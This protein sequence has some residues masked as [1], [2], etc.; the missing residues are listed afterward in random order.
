[1]KKIIESFLDYQ[2]K[3]NKSELTI[4]SYVQEIELFIDE[5]DVK[6]ADELR[7][8]SDLDFLMNEWLEKM[9]KKYAPQTVNKKQ[10]CLSAFSNYL[11]LKNIIPTNEIKKINKVKN[12]IKKIDIYTDEEINT[13]FNY[14]ENKIKEDKFKRKVDREVFKMQ[15]CII[16]LL[17]TSGMRISEVVKMRL[18]DIDIE[19]TN[20][21]NIRGKGYND[22]V[23]RKNS[24][25]NKVAEELKEYLEIRKTINIKEGDEFLFISPLN[26]KHIN[27][28][29]VRMFVR[30]MFEELGIKGTLHE[31]R[32]TKG[33]MLVEKGVDIEKVALFLGHAN[34]DTTKRFY[35]KSTDKE[36][37][38]LANL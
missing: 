8:L 2:T 33:S 13:I 35:V 24:F 14:L 28:Q 29:T 36:M 37:E 22:K 9:T 4:K 19:N 27:E 6:S 23:S 21:F 18:V 10:I 25:N 32:H 31:F 38:E 15:R 12:D 30:R 26:K 16:K 3:L 34:S 5:F 7:N 1:M 11:V 20:S 17:Y